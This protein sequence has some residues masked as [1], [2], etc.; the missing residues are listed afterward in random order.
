MVDRLI[1]CGNIIEI[2]SDACRPAH[3]HAIGAVA[4]FP[5]R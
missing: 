4:E 5:P 3:K 2:G 1:F